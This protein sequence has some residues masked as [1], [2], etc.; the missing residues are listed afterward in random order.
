[1]TVAVAVLTPLTVLSH[2]VT[3]AWFVLAFM[4][5]ACGYV[6]S[7]V[8]RHVLVRTAVAA[9]ISV[10]IYFLYLRPLVQGWASTGNP[11]PVLISFAAQVGVPALSLALFGACVIIAR[12]RRES[13]VWWALMFAGSLCLFQLTTINWNP[14]YFLFFFPAV[15]ILAAYGMD[16]IAGSLGRGVTAAAWYGAVA[17]LLLP[18]LLSHFQDGTRHDYRRAAQVLQAH[19]LPGQVILSDDAETISYYLPAGLRQRLDVRTRVRVLPE[20]E[21]FLVTR[22]NAWMPLPRIAGRQLELLEEIYKRRFDEFSHIL[23]V[24]RVPPAD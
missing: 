12:K 14:R 11:T 10:L 7:A 21:F 5:A 23:R 3:V 1:M 22:S 19:A 4:A 18:S 8:P 15:W 6:V 13:I 9:T 17:L 2:N 24:Y 20:S 16:A